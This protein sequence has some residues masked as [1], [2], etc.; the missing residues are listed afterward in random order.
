MSDE[1]APTAIRTPRYGVLAV[2]LLSLELLA[3]VQT[4]LLAT[5]VP[6]VAADLHAHQ[7]YGVITGA[8]QV[9]TFVTMPLGP[10][11]L[12]RVPVNRLLLLL[13]WVAVAGGVVSALAPDVAVFVAGRLIGGLA[14]GG[15]ATVSLAA[16][17]SVLPASWRR[18]VLAG[19]NVAWVVVSLVGPLYAG[20]VASTLGWRWALVLYLPLLL[21]A[22]AVVARQ[23]RGTMGGGGEE[24]LPL[25]W[26]LMLALGVALLSVIGVRAVPVVV[27]VAT[28]VVGA[29]LALVAAARLLPPGVFRVR[30]GR[31]AAVATMGLVTGAFFGAE[32]IVAIVVHDVLG[33]GTRAVAV[34]LGVGTLAWALLG[35]YVARRPA[36]GAG[37]YAHRSGL[38]AALMAAGLM[39][40][41]AA[42]SFGGVLLVGLGWTV[43]GVGMGLV[44]LD[45]LNHIVEPPQEADGVT[46]ARAAAATV[47]VEAVATAVTSTLAAAALGRVV[48]G[49]MSVPVVTGVLV[50]CAVLA[51]GVALTARRAV[52]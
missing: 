18:L 14:A 44:Y 13:T 5:V 8:A 51:V 39:A 16:I 40:M 38:G 27:V 46:P 24:P 52:V 2:A 10:W 12:R 23:L 37:T 22:R 47:L 7:Y 26:A 28:A 30:R 15:L 35:L 9:A 21:A 42:P 20:W 4:Y 6:L 33:D 41:A 11:L 1:H 36:S 31:A 49:G 34:V 45:T 43:A 19:Y 3:G 25:A 48:D 17:V 32:A 29:G 50:G